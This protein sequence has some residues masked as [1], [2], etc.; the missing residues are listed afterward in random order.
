MNKTLNIIFDNIGKYITPFLMLYG[1]ISNT[2]LYWYITNILKNYSVIIY[3]F[4]LSNICGIVATSYFYY[5]TI[6]KK[7]KL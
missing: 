5:I 1:F 6:I 7:E 2:F 3:L 4:F